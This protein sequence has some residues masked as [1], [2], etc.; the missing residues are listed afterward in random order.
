MYSGLV[1]F[2]AASTHYRV[3]RN[4]E[5]PKQMTIGKPLVH[6][7]AVAVEEVGVNAMAAGSDGPICAVF[8]AFK[9][10]QMLNE[11]SKSHV[12]SFFNTLVYRVN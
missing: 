12:R 6:T 5:I 10:V 7:M 3:C 4:L 8:G 2:V 9:A 1:G 11:A